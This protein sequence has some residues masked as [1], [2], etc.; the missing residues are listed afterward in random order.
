M[1]GTILDALW[2]FGTSLLIGVP[3]IFGLYILCTP[4]HKLMDTWRAWKIYKTQ[5]P[6]KDHHFK[7]L[8]RNIMILKCLSVLLVAGAVT[9]LAL[10]VMSL[11]TKRNAYS[12]AP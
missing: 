7:S 9:T 2:W 1:V 4:R 3:L 11:L 12:E 10:V 5:R 6:L 8:P